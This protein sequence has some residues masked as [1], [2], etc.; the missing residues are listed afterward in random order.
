M[1][2]EERGKEIEIRKKV[3]NQNEIK[4]KKR[5]KTERG[6]AFGCGVKKLMKLVT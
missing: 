3:E 6:L 5:R 4:V 2:V 1:D